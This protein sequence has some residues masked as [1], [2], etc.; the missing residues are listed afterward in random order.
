MDHAVW[1]T[2]DFNNQERRIALKIKPIVN[3]PA[4]LDETKAHVYFFIVLGRPTTVIVHPNIKS[5]PNNDQF[6]RAI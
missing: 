5:K 2:S 4:C 3:L 6:F 1:K